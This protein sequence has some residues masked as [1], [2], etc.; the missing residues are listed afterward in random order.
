MF[1]L[2]PFLKLKKPPDLP[3]RGFCTKTKEPRPSGARGSCLYVFN[4]SKTASSVPLA[5]YD[6][7]K[8]E[9]QAVRESLMDHELPFRQDNLALLI[10]GNGGDVKGKIR[11]S[12]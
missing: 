12:G 7:A 8:Y 4:P 11:E 3:S 5:Y 10:Y 2:A 1:C 6:Y 9:K